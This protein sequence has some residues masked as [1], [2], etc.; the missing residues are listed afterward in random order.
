MCECYACSMCF[1]EYRFNCNYTHMILLI[2]FCR[3]WISRILARPRGHALLVGVR[4]SGKQ[5][6]DPP[7]RPPLQHGCVPAHPQQGLQHTG[8]KGNR[9]SRQHNTINGIQDE[10]EKTTYSRN[11]NKYDFDIVPN[12]RNPH[13]LPKS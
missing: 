12:H 11:H 4:G 2:G 8:P 9:L 7:C 1:S 13:Q 3:C 10:N 5:K 6:P